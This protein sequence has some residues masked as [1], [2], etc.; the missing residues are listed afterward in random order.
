MKTAILQNNNFEEGGALINV[1]G[2]GQEAID[3]VEK[4]YSQKHSYG[5]IL[6]DLQMPFMNGYECTYIIRNYI[7]N[8]CNDLQP[9]IVACSGH[10]ESEYILKAF[11]YEMDEFI[12]KPVQ[13]EVMRALM[14]DIIEIKGDN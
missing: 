11:R 9:V 10:S 1:A 5:L 14:E 12:F 6:M 2:S 8:Q 3:L 7:K 4:A 13:I